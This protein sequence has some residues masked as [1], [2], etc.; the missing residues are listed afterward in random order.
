MLN[1]PELTLKELIP[2]LHGVDDTLI[3]DRLVEL[4]LLMPIAGGF[5]P[6][7]RAVNYEFKN[8]SPKLTLTTIGIQTLYK[9]YRD[10]E[11]PMKSDWNGSFIK[12]KAFRAMLNQNYNEKLYRGSYA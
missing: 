6:L 4:Q 9:L 8:T 7:Q 2:M 12:P 11:L 10:E 1:E 3:Y 5:K